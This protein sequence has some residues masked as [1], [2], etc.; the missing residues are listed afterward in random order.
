MRARS[1]RFARKKG[2]SEVIGALL[3]MLVVVIAVGTFAFY[4]SNLQKQGEARNSYLNSVKNDDLQITNLQLFPNDPNTMYQFKFTQVF[5]GA[6]VISPTLNYVDMISGGIKADNYSRS[7]DFYFGRGSYYNT[8]ASGIAGYVCAPSGA[9]NP[10][11][12]NFPVCGA[13]CLSSCAGSSPLSP[14]SSS[15]VLQTSPGSANCGNITTGEYGCNI[16]FFSAYW[17]SANVTV[18][19]LNTQSSGV[20]SVELNS[21]WLNGF[22]ITLPAAEVTPS[23]Q[24]LFSSNSSTGYTTLSPLFLESE[25]SQ[26][27]YLNLSPFSISRNVS[28]SLTLLSTAGNYFSS[29]F[30]APSALIQ[31]TVVPNNDNIYT[32]DVPTFSGT[33]SSDINGT[34]QNYMWQ[35]NIQNSTQTSTIYENGPLFEYLPENFLTSGELKNPNL[36]LDGPLS[37]TLVAVNQFGIMSTPAVISFSGDPQITPVADITPQP[38]APGDQYSPTP[39]APGVVNPAGTAICSGAPMFVAVNVTDIF[40]RP[41]PGGIPVSFIPYGSVTIDPSYTTVDTYQVMNPNAPNDLISI[42]A[43]KIDSCTSGASI[44]ATPGNLH[45]F[46]IPLT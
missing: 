26:T 46:I 10:Y 12:P 44:G 33:Q 41:V 7:Y 4:L 14:T 5:A 8:I 11:G 37:I 40:G 3:L 38:P 30:S 18:R 23:N 20:S 19:D 36:G 9:G 34:I 29:F 1:R 25:S 32:V 16:Q 2:I 22:Y 17:Y 24:G 39:P 45:P 15:I 13:N 42:A 6:T 21:N 31:S 28:I 27:L 35:M 43:V